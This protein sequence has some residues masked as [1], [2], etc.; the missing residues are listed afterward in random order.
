MRSLVAR[1]VA[2]ALG[3]LL[4]AEVFVGP[5]GAFAAGEPT[6]SISSTLDVEISGGPTTGRL[7]LNVTFEADAS[8]GIAPYNYTWSFGS[9][10]PVVFGPSA[11]HT[12]SV[13]GS[14]NVT[15]SVL[16]DF[17]EP[18]NASVEVT[19]LPMVLS[20]ILSAVPSSVAAGSPTYLE[21]SAAGGVPPYGYAWSGLPNGC[22]GGDF[23]SIRCVPADA[24]GFTI[25]VNVTDSTGT[26][27]SYLAG[28]VVTPGNSSCPCPGGGG[29][30]GGVALWEIGALAVAAAVAGAAIGVVVRPRLRRPR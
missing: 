2:L 1:A 6:S 16:D 29:S 26:T 22:V 7:P 20:V 21:A 13:A 3:A 10:G 11:S 5:L 17:G 23:A 27:A 15:V 8:G 12:F 24:G 19:V 28:L 25:Y 9:G 14:Y 4:L 30:S 18:G